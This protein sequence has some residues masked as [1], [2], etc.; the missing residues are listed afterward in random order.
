MVKEKKRRR[1]GRFP[2]QKMHTLASRIQ[3][4]T[5]TGRG[6]RGTRE[7]LGVGV[8]VVALGI[9]HGPLHLPCPPTGRAAPSFLSRGSRPCA[10]CREVK[11]PVGRGPPLQSQP[12]HQPTRDSH[13]GPPEERQEREKVTT[14]ALA[15]TTCQVLTL[16]WA[17]YTN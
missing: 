4:V 1:R 16:C 14:T 10:S 3:P 11:P 5:D 15:A 13:S 2:P 7:N 12:P 8:G 17:L 6:G 9:H